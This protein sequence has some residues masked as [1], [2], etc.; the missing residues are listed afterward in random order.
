LLFLLAM[1]K[2]LL[3]SSKVSRG[4]KT[5]KGFTLIEALVA[6]A[7]I[8]ILTALV[9]PQV[10]AFNKPLQN[11]TNQVVGI[12]RQTRLRAI[13]NT[14]AY[15]LRPNNTTSFTVESSTTRGCGSLT[16]LRVDATAATTVLQVNSARG[17]FIGDKIRVGSDT[18]DNDITGTDATNQT[19]TLGGT[20]LGSAQAANTT[21]EL[22]SN[23]RQGD[24]FTSFTQEALTLPQSRT[25]FGSIQQNPSEIVRMQFA[26]GSIA[27]NTWNASTNWNLCFNSVGIANIVD[28]TTGLS[29]NQD[30]QITLQ[31]F[32]TETNTVLGTTTVT[33]AAGGSVQT[34]PADTLKISQ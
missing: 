23:W 12:L 1:S 15:R 10:F 31:R 29:L 34:N 27:T 3:S 9:G 20:G 22:L 8:G 30:L 17:F 11:G 2:L 5:S 21:V 4:C 14:T 19:I 6:I 24:L 25:W 16:Q 13:A 33:V 28:L 7:I 18:T 32:S 26:T